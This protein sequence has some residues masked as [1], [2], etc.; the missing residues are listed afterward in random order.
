[1]TD[2]G[3]MQN[4]NSTN[5]DYLIV[6]IQET[7]YAFSVYIVQEIIPMVEIFSSGNSHCILGI[8]NLRGETIPVVDFSG[9][10]KK[11]PISINS[12]QKLVVLSLNSERFAIIADELFDIVNIRDA[13]LCTLVSSEDCIKNVIINGKPVEV[14]DN[15]VFCRIFPS[16][17]SIKNEKSNSLIPVKD[18]SSELI[19][20]HTELINKEN[21]FSLSDNTFFNEKFIVFKLNNETYA[22][23]IL[24]TLEIIKITPDDVSRIP[25]VP[26]FIR[27]IIGIDG[28]YI[29]VIDIRPFL[30]LDLPEFAGPT[31]VILLCVNDMKLAVPVDEIVA[32]DRLQTPKM[33]TS[34]LFSD[35]YIKGEIT[36]GKTI[37]N[38]LDVEKLFSGNNVN[39]EN[40]ENL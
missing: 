14:V 37:I 12:E 39:I 38:M 20:M 5:N 25:S 7:L 9:F 19:K 23:N 11:Q 26:D 18:A 27:G 33:V 8:M 2:I 17:D 34:E 24:Y 40:Y 30:N 15:Y 32:I 29:S 36:D 4:T 10:L 21:A 1:M 31:P 13:E 16:L 22:F 28:E 3:Y 35:S 6:K